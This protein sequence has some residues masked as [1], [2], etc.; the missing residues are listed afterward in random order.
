M[1]E[2]CQE[3]IF[4]V[5]LYHIHYDYHKFQ[6]IQFMKDEQNCY[7]HINAQGEIHLKRDRCALLI[8]DHFENDSKRYA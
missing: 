1:H 5:Y 4:K 8:V 3:I 7:R 2:I 6:P